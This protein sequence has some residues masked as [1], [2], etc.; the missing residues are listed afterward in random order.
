MLSDFETE[1]S[2]A[3]TQVLAG[4]ERGFRITSAI[5]RLI[6]EFAQKEQIDYIL[7]DIG[8]NLGVL[9]RAMLLSCDSYVIPLIPDMFS[10]RGISNIGRV[11]ANWIKDYQFSLNRAGRFDFNIAPGYPKYSGYILQQFNKYRERP[12]QAFQRWIDQVPNIIT[13]YMVEPLTTAELADFNLV[14]RGGEGKLAEFRNYFSLIP[15]AQ[16]ARKP[17]FDLTNSDGVVGAHGTYVQRCRE[18]FDVI[19]E[20]FIERIPEN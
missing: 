19:C 1:L 12:V 8:P 4:L 5:Y 14:L 2:T 11:F 9:N 3:W 20:S 7:I 16:E 15:L 18:D 10:L 6:D 13:T 17:I